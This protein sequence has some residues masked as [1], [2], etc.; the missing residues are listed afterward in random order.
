MTA[1]G[2]LDLSPWL[3]VMPA[4]LA[5]FKDLLMSYGA[6]DGF[7]AVQYCSVL[8]D[9]AVATGAAPGLGPAAP[10][11][12]GGTAADEEARGGSGAAG[13][14]ATAAAVGR[15]GAQQLTERQ[16][17]QVVAVAQVGGDSCFIPL[18]SRGLKCSGAFKCTL[19]AA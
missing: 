1:R 3:Y 2:S 7:S 18:C 15:G 19:Q 13:E 6:A 10:A 5:P 14:G 8:H 17:G 12:P 16:L 4:E 9:M 11:T